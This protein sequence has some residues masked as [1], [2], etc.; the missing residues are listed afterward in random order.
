[1][2]D[3]NIYQRVNKVMQAVEYVQKDATVDT[4]RGSYKAVSHDMV[5]A[6]LRKE[7]VAQG[8]VTRVEQLR[9]EVLV[10]ADKSKEIKQH[11]YSGDYAVHFH[12]MDKPED[13]LTVTVNGHAADNQ[14]K[15]PGKAMSYAVKYAMLKT[16]GLETGENDEGRFADYAPFTEIQKDEFHSFIQANNDPLGFLCFTKTVGDDVFGALQGTFPAGQIVSGKKIANGLVTQGFEILNNTV[17]T[18]QEHINNRDTDGLLEIIEAYDTPVSKRL[19][20]GLLNAEQLK[21]LRDVRELA[22]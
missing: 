5:L 19:L 7:M 11:L 4:G 14:D 3:L 12:N 6:V 8:I 16:F 2:S 20:G 18:I 10:F 22:A 21:A 15:A 17:A 1:M 9:S 13:C